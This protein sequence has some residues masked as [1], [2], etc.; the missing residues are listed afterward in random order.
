VQCKRACTRLGLTSVFSQGAYNAD[1]AGYKIRMRSCGPRAS[2][3]C[4]E[5]AEGNN[6]YEDGCTAMHTTPGLLTTCQKACPT[7]PGTY[8]VETK[9]RDVVFTDANT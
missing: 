9:P 6:D 8:D 7:V 5:W 3:A 2:G 4:T 1:I